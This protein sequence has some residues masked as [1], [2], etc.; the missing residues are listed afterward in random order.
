MTAAEDQAR[1][2]RE[3]ARARVQDAAA[4]IAAHPS[5]RALADSTSI[6]STIPRSL[7]VELLEAFDALHDLELPVGMCSPQR[8]SNVARSLAAARKGDARRR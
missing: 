5:E 6:Y 4:R 7:I 1:W 2:A 8:A 3:D